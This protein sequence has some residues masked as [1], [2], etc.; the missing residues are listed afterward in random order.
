[1][2]WVYVLYNKNAKK[3][4]TGQTEDLELRISQHNDHT[5][6]VSHLDIREYG[7]LFTAKLLHL[8]PRL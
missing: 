1:M 5:L 6:I 4:Y 3:T 2:F 8:D 7:S